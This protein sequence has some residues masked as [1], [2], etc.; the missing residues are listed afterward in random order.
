MLHTTRSL[1]LRKSNVLKNPNKLRVRTPT[2]ASI[3]LNVYQRTGTRTTR[4]SSGT[5][6]NN[7]N[8][9][10]PPV[11]AINKDGQNLFTPRAFLGKNS[12]E[13]LDITKQSSPKFLPNAQ[14]RF[15]FYNMKRDSHMEAQRRTERFKR[16]IIKE[17]QH[18]RNLSDEVRVSKALG[19]MPP[20]PAREAWWK[21]MQANPMTLDTV[22][23]NQGINLNAND[24]NRVEEIVAM[25]ERQGVFFGESTYNVL[26][27]VYL[28]HGIG[29]KAMA[30]FGKI[31]PTNPSAYNHLLPYVGITRNDLDSCLALLDDMQRRGI[32]PNHITLVHMIKIYA[33]HGK[34]EEAEKLVKNSQEINRQL[35]Y[36]MIS[37]YTKIGDYASG[38]R[39]VQNTKRKFG[40]DAV[41]YRSI[42]QL[43]LKMKKY[44][45]VQQTFAELK[46][47]KQDPGQFGYSM[48]LSAYVQTAKYEDAFSLFEYMQRNMRL[49]TIIYDT[50]LQAYVHL[51][52]GKNA[53]AL[54]D[55]ME[56]L[57]IYPSDILYSKLL[58]LFINKGNFEQVTQILQRMER[59]NVKIT[60]LSLRVLVP[61]YAKA[62]DYE[63]VNNYLGMMESQN[64]PNQKAVLETLLPVY[65]A[66]G[67]KQEASELS[68]K[69][70]KMS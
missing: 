43:Y 24:V 23:W 45:L 4:R 57:R 48:L 70:S 44:D 18:S 25:M 55:D 9:N 27:K 8:N 3:S 14:G 37:S 21:Y 67:K 6:N 10:N 41:G 62:K 2:I 53:L 58:Q 49:S 19:D 1:F 51:G 34:M 47:S 5:N 26:L 40:I 54:F 32:S 36:C 30:V 39:W 50:I 52:M 63:K 56:K 7:N 35:Y 31:E 42:M 17:G 15:D 29:D 38:E 69:I 61:A 12:P 33:H 20:A 68:E 13:D 46:A 64:M 28:N 65:L 60:Q 11:G 22:L 66:Q 16:S 59:A